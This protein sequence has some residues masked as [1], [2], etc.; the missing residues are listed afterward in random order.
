MKKAGLWHDVGKA[1]EAFQ[2][3]LLKGIEDE[4]IINSG[5]WAKS[6]KRS[7]RPFYHTIKKNIIKK[8][9]GNME[10]EVIRVERKFFRHELASALSYMQ[11]NKDDSH[12]NLIT[13]LIGAHHG[14]VRLSI[15]SLPDETEPEKGGLFARGVWDGDIIPAI[16][17][18]TRNDVNIDLSPMSIGA[19]SWLERSLEVLDEYGPFRLAFLE[20]LLRISDWEVSGRYKHE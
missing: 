6:D 2:N 16:R 8:D 7:G 18:L 13:Y 11:S 3:N 12:V 17:G 10:E 1:H 20:S 15:R 19:G 4:R 5:P 14:K 9:G